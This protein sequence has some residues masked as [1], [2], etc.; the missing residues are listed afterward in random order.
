MAG[1]TM[2][3]EKTPPSPEAPVTE[4]AGGPSPAGASPASRWGFAI[5]AVI[6]L[7][8]LFW[9][10]S[11]D[12]RVNFQVVRREHAKG[13]AAPVGTLIDSSGRQVPLGTRMA[14]VTLIH[15]WATWC[16]PCIGEIPSIL[17]LADDYAADHDFSLVMIAVQDEVAKVKTFLGSRTG[18]SL[19]DHD[20]RVTH[21]Y[22]TEKVPETHLV[23]GGELVESFIG[24]T[25]WDAPETRE[26]IA[27]ALAE[28]QGEE[29]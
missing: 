15:F 9:P 2:N 27:E 18:E 17:R 12:D 10:R 4:T 13:P 23:V 6:A 16:P 24:A 11:E 1:S 3:D 25:N 29:G 14:P 28:V 21:S 20:W 22:G 7:A 8:A 26:R 5:V 19:F